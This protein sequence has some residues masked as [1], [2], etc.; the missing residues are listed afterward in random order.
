M[1]TIDRIYEICG[2]D[3]TDELLAES[4]LKMN[5]Y[6]RENK[7]SLT[8]E[9]S[10]AH[11]YPVDILINELFDFK[12]NVFA[13]KCK[14]PE[15]CYPDK[16]ESLELTYA[17]RYFQG[18]GSK[19]LSLESFG[20]DLIMLVKISKSEVTTVLIDENNAVNNYVK[21]YKKEVD[22][23]TIERYTSFLNFVEG[24]K[25]TITTSVPKLNSWLNKVRNR[26]FIKH[27]VGWMYL[28]ELENEVHS[29]LSEYNLRSG[30]VTFTLTNK[31]LGLIITQKGNKK[32]GF[33]LSY[34]EDAPVVALTAFD[35]Y[36][37]DCHGSQ[38]LIG[39]K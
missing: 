26:N 3:V 2:K 22:F 27:P 35:K 37:L 16:L 15:H 24:S 21:I 8:M 29:I 33:D 11:K 39:T 32:Y 28:D 25:Y 20:E 4:T 17:H 7:V 31:S 5:T 19:K 30:V 10:S 34:I 6:I 23:N 12:D 38:E 18:L 13:L 9:Q 14:N 1:I 36:G